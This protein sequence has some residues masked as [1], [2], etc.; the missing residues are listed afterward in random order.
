MGA[1][2]GCHTVAIAKLANNALEPTAFCTMEVRIETAAAQR[3][4]L[5]RYQ[6]MMARN[7]PICVNGNQK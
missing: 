7:L 1:S 2:V 3:G 6:A 5:G 4:R